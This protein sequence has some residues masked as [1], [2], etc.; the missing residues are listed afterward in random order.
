MSDK[1][2]SCKQRASHVALD[3]NARFRRDGRQFRSSRRCNGQVPFLTRKLREAHRPLPVGSVH[4]CMLMPPSA[5]TYVTSNIRRHRSAEPGRPRLGRSHPEF[6][7]SQP[8]SGGW[9]N[10]GKNLRFLSKPPC[11]SPKTKRAHFLRCTQYLLSTGFRERPLSN[12]THTKAS[13]SP[14][15]STAW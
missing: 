1:R 11:A 3:S 12:T 4:E 6:G 5:G 2:L 9:L 10:L 8:T 7:R 15:L 14:C 13:A